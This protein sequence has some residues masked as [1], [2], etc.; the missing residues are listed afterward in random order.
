MK[1]A[2]SGRLAYSM[3]PS[4]RICSPETVSRSDAKGIIV[5]VHDRYCRSF[6]GASPEA[7]FEVDREATVCTA[8]RRF[9][10]VGGSGT[11]Q[12][13]I[14]QMLFS[15]RCRFP[16]PWSIEETDACFIVKDSA[17]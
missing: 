8:S 4:L 2:G 11:P 14:T 15:R 6:I 3:R 1:K 12:S 17:G 9:L 7:S 13:S 5:G 16:P 10:L